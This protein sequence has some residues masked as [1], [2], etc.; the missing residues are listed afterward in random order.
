MPGRDPPRL[1]ARAPLTDPST[2]AIGT[3]V[4]SEPGAWR[5]RSSEAIRNA[6]SGI[7]SGPTISASSPQYSTRRS[8]TIGPSAR[9]GSA[10]R[11]GA[12]RRRERKAREVAAV[13]RHPERGHHERSPP[14][15]AGARGRDEQQR[16]E[17]AADRAEHHAPSEE[18]GDVVAR[19]VD[20]RDLGAV[21]EG[22]GEEAERGRRAEQQRKRVRQ[23]EGEERERRSRTRRSPR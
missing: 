23:P 20:Q 22:G 18:G 16:S 3:A 14:A 4:A 5:T 21:H 2:H 7:C 10:V 19:E 6:V 17:D 1:A 13:G 8:R 11:I 12:R 9:D 15:R